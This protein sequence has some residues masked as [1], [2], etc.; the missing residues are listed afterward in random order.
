MQAVDRI[1]NYNPTVKDANIF[2]VIPD[3]DIPW[4]IRKIQKCGF[5]G[6]IV[7]V[8]DHR[9]DSAD[10]VGGWHISKLY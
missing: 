2:G 10:D 9:P 5:E 4:I 7:N 3:E 8:H 6:V 1:K